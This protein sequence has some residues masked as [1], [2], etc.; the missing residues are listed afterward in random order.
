MARRPKTEHREARYTLWQ[1]SAACRGKDQNTFYGPDAP[2]STTDRNNREEAAKLVCGTCSV[3]A[4]CLRYSLARHETY[5]I[6]GGTT[7]RERR[8]LTLD[9]VPDVIRRR[10]S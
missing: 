3:K 4:E 1:E 10:V 6:W 5:G 7:E 8:G 9:E 2:E